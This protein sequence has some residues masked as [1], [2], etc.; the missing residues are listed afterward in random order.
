VRKNSIS[1]L[2]PELHWLLM[3]RISSIEGLQGQCRGSPLTLR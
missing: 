3:E 1:R 2:Y